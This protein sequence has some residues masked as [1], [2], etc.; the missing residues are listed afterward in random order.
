MLQLLHIMKEWTAALENGGQINTI[1]IDFEKAFDKVPH[2][3]LFKKLQNYNLKVNV[4][5]WIRSFLCYRKQ[6][7][8]INGCY[9]EWADV[10]SG[11]PQST[12]LGPILFMI[13]IN[14]LP[15]ICKQF[16]RIYLFADDAKLFKH[17]ICDED[18]KALQLGLNALQDWSNKWLLNLNILKCRTVFFGRNINKNYTYF[19]QS[20]L[21][22]RLEHMKDLGV[23][24]DSE[25]N[26]VA[27]VQ[28]CKE[29]IN[30]AY[31]Y[32]GIIKRNFVYLDEDAFV[33]LYKSLVR[34]HLEYAN[35]V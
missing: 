30:T 25:L 9:S 12:I 4:I 31:S 16:A 35:S 8:K 17:V 29:N 19:L 28:H 20:T 21:L 14:D 26:S 15:E 34:S 2:H 18:H 32:L 1:Y 13:Y 23:I 22:E 10:I 5:Q 3:L 7:I 6:R 24:F 33:M 11:I 27:L